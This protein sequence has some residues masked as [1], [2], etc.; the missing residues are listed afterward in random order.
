LIESTGNRTVA[1]PTR[2]KA[3]AN[4]TLGASEEEVADDVED[5]GVGEEG[6]G[7]AKLSLPLYKCIFNLLRSKVL[8]DDC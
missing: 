6:T 4:K 5:L 7:M 8:L 3:P 2:A 1:E